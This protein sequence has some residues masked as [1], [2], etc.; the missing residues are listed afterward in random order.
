MKTVEVKKANLSLLD[1]AKKAAKEPVIITDNGKPVA[2][3]VSIHNADMETA[4]LSNNRQ[5]LALI[6]RSR[7][8]LKAEGGLSAAEMQK[9]LRKPKE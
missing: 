6:E 2:A 5:F 7:A 9:R 3:L 1:Y 8:R 4:S